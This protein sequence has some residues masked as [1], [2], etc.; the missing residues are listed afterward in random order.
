[1]KRLSSQGAVALKIILTLL[2]IP[3]QWPVYLHDQPCFE[4]DKVDNIAVDWH[5]PFELPA[6]QALRTK[7]TPECD[8]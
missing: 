3:M 6:V 4:A 1:M 7:L 2:R 5:L 8:L